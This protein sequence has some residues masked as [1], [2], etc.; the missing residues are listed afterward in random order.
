MASRP[1]LQRILNDAL[2]KAAHAA[3]ALNASFPASNLDPSLLSHIFIICSNDD[4]GDVEEGAPYADEV[5]PILVFSQVCV[6]WRKVAFE[7]PLLWRQFLLPQS[8]TLLTHIL[9]RTRAIPLHVRI[10]QNELGPAWDCMKMIAEHECARLRILSL[11][12]DQIWF[13]FCA[14]L[15]RS[16]GLYLDTLAL[17]VVSTPWLQQYRLPE[18]FM[19]GTMPVL[20]SLTTFNVGVPWN[21]PV[22]SP[23]LVFLDMRYKA[24]RLPGSG[25][26]HH[27]IQ[28]LSTMQFLRSLVLI[29]A[30][31]RW[32]TIA[33]ATLG[34]SVA[35]LLN[36]ETLV[37]HDQ[38][39]A[40]TSF[41]G[42]LVLSRTIDI[43]IVVTGVDARANVMDMMVAFTRPM[44]PF[45]TAKLV[46][47][48]DGQLQLFAWRTLVSNIPIYP[49]FAEFSF[50]AQ[51]G[52]VI[53]YSAKILQLLSS[54]RRLS[55]FR[56]LDD[57]GAQLW[58][59][60]ELL[61]A[62]DNL[63]ELE[64]GRHLPR[65][66]GA[67][68]AEDVESPVILAPKLR[69]LVLRDLS[70]EGGTEETPDDNPYEG[71]TAWLAERSEHLAPLDA[72]SLDYCRGVG[73]TERTVLAGSVGCLTWKEYE[74][75]TASE[76][77]EDSEWLADDE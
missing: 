70:L 5:P 41:L 18:H 14:G 55:M 57:A 76:S 38:A 64:L 29:G 72:L 9:S 39:A 13:Y 62:V 1:G 16:P 7:N 58:T 53:P 63:L 52:D 22:L 32:N 21:H 43:E 48:G 65:T 66:F 67:I 8:P 30:L 77:E 51:V 54:W 49:A 68:Y 35:R 60:A 37:V 20:R 12:A 11:R 24:L 75:D 3:Q 56:V 45:I 44:Q 40:L 71:L 31:P 47:R 50:R 6:H 74:G 4:F 23:T 59:W 61:S 10:Q 73:D 34:P 28:T 15:M 46:L 33:T 2:V 19:G 69:A 36:L 25:T 42:G 27:A 26:I 17:A